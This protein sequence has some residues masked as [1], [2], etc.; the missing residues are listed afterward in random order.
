MTEKFILTKGLMSYFHQ[1]WDIDGET[2]IEVVNYFCV[3]NPDVS[4]KELCTEL[5]FLICEYEGKEAELAALLKELGNEYY[6][7]ADNLSAT[8]WVTKLISFLG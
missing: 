1:D 6:Y 4:T 3:N 5:K 2:D 7:Q 8:Q